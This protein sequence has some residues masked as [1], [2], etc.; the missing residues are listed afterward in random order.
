[1]CVLLHLCMQKLQGLH[2][3]PSSNFVNFDIP[4]GLIT[5]LEALNLLILN[6]GW[7]SDQA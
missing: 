5:V 4:E 2:I 6:P 7:D 1:M 3:Y